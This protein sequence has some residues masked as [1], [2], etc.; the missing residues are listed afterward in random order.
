MNVSIEAFLLN[1]LNF[2]ISFIEAHLVFIKAVQSHIRH[3]TLRLVQLLVFEE[4][5]CTLL[6]KLVLKVAAVV[7]PLNFRHVL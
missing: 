7:F 6:I 4:P 3:I 2:L 1:I 5:K